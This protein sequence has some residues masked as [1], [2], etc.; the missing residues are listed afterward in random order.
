MLAKLLAKSKRKTGLVNIVW[1]CL[2]FQKPRSRGAK[3]MGREA[4]IVKTRTVK[5]STKVRISD[6]KGMKE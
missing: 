1:K 4:R 2:N 5:G 6:A 3:A